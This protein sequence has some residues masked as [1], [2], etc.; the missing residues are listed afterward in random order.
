M[1]S[2]EELR[3]YYQSTL[4]PQ[5]RILEKQRKSVLNKIIYA[6]I[7]IAP[8]TLWLASMPK[9][10]GNKFFIGFVGLLAWFISV[11]VFSRKYV[12]S[13]KDQI[14]QK[15]ISAVVP[16]FNYSKDK[17]ISKQLFL[18]S[19]IF[20]ITPNRYKG[21]DYISGK[22]GATNVEFS[23][24]HA[25]YVSGGKNSH[26]TPIFDGLFL[27]ADFNKNFKGK[28]VILP[29]TA[30]RIF[31]KLANMFQSLKKDKGQL[32][33]LEDPEFEKL[34]A[35]YGN[36]QIEARY[37]LSTSLMRRI[38]DYRKKANKRIYLSFVGS[39][40]FVGIAYIKPL[41]EPRIFKTILDFAP[42]E[43]YHRDLQLAIGLVEDLNLNTRIWSKE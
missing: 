22:V 28:T 12:K 31:G 34:F 14:V 9:D 26:T 4:L 13:F 11:A 40:I 43:E 35:V 7:I 29:D 30:E 32:I 41:F 6:S 20:S 5:L 2:I 37:I 10:F 17:H 3:N 27:I 1:K 33:K 39:K 42:I 23:E 19:D 38:V 15:L 25:K 8:V 36:D 21:D 16:D 18:S 24:I